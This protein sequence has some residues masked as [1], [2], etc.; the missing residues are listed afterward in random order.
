MKT[1]DDIQGRGFRSVS[2]EIQMYLD[3]TTNEVIDTWKNPWTEKDIEV[4]H[5]A[6]DP[7]NMRA[8]ESYEFDSEGNS[9]R[10]MKARRYSD[11][12]IASPMKFT[13]L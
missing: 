7:V 12:L 3:P 8:I 4:L 5:V 11:M 1:N 13:L 10:K 2:R 6:N 9:S